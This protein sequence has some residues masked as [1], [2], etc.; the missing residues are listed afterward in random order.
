MLGETQCNFFF[1]EGFSWP[2]EQVA[3]W[4]PIG[5]LLFDLKKEECGLWGFIFF[6]FFFFS[7]LM[8]VIF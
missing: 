5:C 4:T 7:R 3:E 1:W 2:L 6:F 8:V